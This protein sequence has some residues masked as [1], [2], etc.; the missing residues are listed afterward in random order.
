[1]KTILKKLL[2]YESL[3][4]KEAKEILIH[5]TNGQYNSSEISSFLTIYMMR[6]IT[7]EE[8][9][10]FRDALLEV[11][12]SLDVRE[13]DLID[14]CGTGGDGKDTFNISTISAIV[15]AASG[16][17]VAKHGNV[18]V[19]SSVGSSNILE[20]LGYTFTND[21]SLL[22]EQLEKTGICFLHAPL[23]HPALKH[24]APIR[25][26]LGLKTFFNMIGPLVN[27]AFPKKQMIGVFSLELAR[28]YG[29]MFQKT[30]TKFAIVHSLDGYDEISLTEKCKIISN[31]GESIMSPSDLGFETIN[32]QNIIAGKNIKNSAEIFVNIL[33]GTATKE[34]TNVVLAN[35][36]L[37]LSLSTPSKN[38]LDSIQIARETI[39][40][41]KAF[42]LLKKIL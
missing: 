29:Y 13:Y 14:I 21:T 22:K 36:G 3:S 23:F 17:M 41:Q 40:S 25:K 18:G 11:C 34:Q 33:N 15:A 10:G 35:A 6:S 9:E 28:T 37:A 30:E 12:I 39:Q 8:L 24:V 2:E 16:Q 7:V 19:S 32:P 27:P 20:Y 4:R 26:E 42:R 38:I 31:T 1:M 5:M